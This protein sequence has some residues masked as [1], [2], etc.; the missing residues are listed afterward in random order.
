MRVL[1]FDLKGSMAHFRPFYSNANSLSYGFPPRSTIAGLLAGIMGYERDQYYDLFSPENAKI[2]VRLMTPIRRVMY[3]VNYVRTKKGDWSLKKIL[4][5]GFETYPM[6]IQ[7]ILAEDGGFLNYRIYFAHE[8]EKFFERVLDTVE[9]G[10]KYFPYMGITEFLAW[11][12]NVSEGNNV[13][14]K[15]DRVIH[16]VAPFSVIDRVDFSR[17]THLLVDKM[18]GHFYLE[19]K[20]RR[21]YPGATG[22]YV[23]NPDAKPIFLKQEVEVISIDGENIIWL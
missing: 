6:S 10:G 5:K 20:F 16:S 21:P 19:G 22:E 23:Y 8:D 13:Q 2:S 7:V 15:N 9:K 4:Y 11:I 3:R 1:K 18:I 14:I 12:E 17:T